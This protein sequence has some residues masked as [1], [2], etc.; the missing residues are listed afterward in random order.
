M[1][2]EIFERIWNLAGDIAIG[3]WIGFLFTKLRRKKKEKIIYNRQH[4]IKVKLRQQIFIFN[5]ITFINYI[6]KKPI[7]LIGFYYYILI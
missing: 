7:T 6:T 4:L 1:T 2:P 3:L 5:I